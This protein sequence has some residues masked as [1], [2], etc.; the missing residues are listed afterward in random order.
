[1]TEKEIQEKA[2]SCKYFYFTPLGT[3]LICKKKN[4]E[5]KSV[6]HCVEW[7]GK[8]CENCTKYKQKK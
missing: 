7:D 4:K 5:L 6:L 2:L 1:M 3:A 8:E